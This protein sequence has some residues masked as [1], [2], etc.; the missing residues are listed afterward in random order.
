VISTALPLIR[1]NSIKPIALLSPRR[2]AVLPELATA[3]EQGLAGFDADAWNAFFLP[4]STP[5]PIVRRLAKATS[6]ALDLPWVRERLEGLGL[7]VPAPERR[8]PEYLTKLVP[9]ELEKW[10]A[11]VKASGASAD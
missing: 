1:G 9:R 6:D 5:E 3:D 2:N 11:P 8:T 10:A 4:R 7:N